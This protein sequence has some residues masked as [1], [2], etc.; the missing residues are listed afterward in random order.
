MY[1]YT[2]VYYSCIY[3]I[4]I[5]LDL[6]ALQTQLAVQL[7]YGIAAEKIS[8]TGSAWSS[9]AGQLDMSCSSPIAW[10]VRSIQ[11]MDLSHPQEN[12]VCFP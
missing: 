6:N 7:R 9:L 2:Y 11:P 3:I 12:L 10:S 1:I 4:C 8:W 5:Y